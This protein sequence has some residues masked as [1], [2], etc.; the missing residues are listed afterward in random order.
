MRNEPHLRA[1]EDQHP[2]RRQLALR[3]GARFES[4]CLFTGSV[5]E[6]AR[7]REH[8]LSCVSAVQEV[9]DLCGAAP[10][11]CCYALMDHL[12]GNT[13][14]IV[15]MVVPCRWLSIINGVIDS[16]FILLHS[17]NTHHVIDLMRAHPQL[18]ICNM[19]Y[20]TT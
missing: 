19:Y 8:A 9:R 18:Y 7:A 5:R 13:A 12:P 3:P 11:L 6:P 17:P 10:I 1:I 2:L 14:E 16:K 4:C 15:W 20:S